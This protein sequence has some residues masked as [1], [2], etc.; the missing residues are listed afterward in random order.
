M[1]SIFIHSKA[2]R[3]QRNALT[4]T[5]GL[6]VQVDKQAS[7]TE[8]KPSSAGYL[9]SFQCSLIPQLQLARKASRND[10]SEAESRRAKRQRIENRFFG[11]MLASTPVLPSSNFNQNSLAETIEESNSRSDVSHARGDSYLK[12]ST[13][14]SAETLNV[15][16]S[17]SGSQLQDE[18]DTFVVID[19]VTSAEGNSSVPEIVTN[20]WRQVVFVQDGLFTV[21]EALHCVQF[22]RDK[23]APFT[24]VR[25]G[26][27]LESKAHSTLLI[28]RPCWL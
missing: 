8:A 10:I 11:Q 21:D 13:L 17:G 3:A 14:T 24:P 16:Y 26:H 18:V 25:L 12:L 19:N 6:T 5:T 4:V 23:L 1:Y 15:L 9:C 27:L 28:A 7:E 20:D 2:A 22:F